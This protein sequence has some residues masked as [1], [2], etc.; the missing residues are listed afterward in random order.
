MEHIGGESAKL[1][2]QK[3]MFKFLK[4]TSRDVGKKAAVPIA[5]IIQLVLTFLPYLLDNCKERRK[6]RIERRREKKRR[7]RLKRNAKPEQDRTE[8]DSGSGSV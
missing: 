6:K 5:L 1:Q 4:K 2:G 7:R 3:T 8:L